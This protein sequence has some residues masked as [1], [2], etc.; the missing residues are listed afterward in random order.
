MRPDKNLERFSDPIGSKNALKTFYPAG[1]AVRQR[2]VAGPVLA[3]A[4]SGRA[5]TPAAWS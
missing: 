3:A 4:G 2:A 5:S 1:V